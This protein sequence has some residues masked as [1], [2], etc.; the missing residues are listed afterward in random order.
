MDF[1]ER[2]FDMKIK[3]YCCSQIIMAMGLED[4]GK[5]NG[6]LVAAMRGLCNG[7]EAGKA[8]GTLSAVLCL[9]YLALPGRDADECREEFMCWFI[10]CFGGCDC[11]EI[12]GGDPAKK[13]S[14]CPSLV[15]GSYAKL[16]EVLFEDRLGCAFDGNPGR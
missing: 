7:M 14:I 3:G 1:S 12:T 8:C 11:D 9:I 4:M 2:I 16:Y 10:D 15:A 6:E 13:L 5:E